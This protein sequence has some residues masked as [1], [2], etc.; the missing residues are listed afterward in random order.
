MENVYAGLVCKRKDSHWGRP[1]YECRGELIDRLINENRKSKDLYLL[2]K[3]DVEFLSAAFID[4]VHPKHEYRL[5]EDYMTLMIANNDVDGAKLV[6]KYY[7]EGQKGRYTDKDLGNLWEDIANHI[8][9]NDMDAKDKLAITQQLIPLIEN[10][11]IRGKKPLSEIAKFQEEWKKYIV[12]VEEEEKFKEGSLLVEDKYA[13]RKTVSPSKS[14][15]V[16]P[17]DYETVEEYDKAVRAAYY[18]IEEEKIQLR[19]NGYVKDNIFSFCRVDTMSSSNGVYYYST[20]NLE[21]N[22]GDEVVVPFGEENK[23]TTGI[24]V[25]VGKCYGSAFPFEPTKIKTVIKR[26]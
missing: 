7:L 20:G 21:L 13:W 12:D 18:K 15:L 24:V 11:G 2:L 26:K 6:Y 4:C 19:R 8:S 23:E 3:S 10:I 9:W 5:V 1:S 17:L 16:N 22:V 25:S 14:S